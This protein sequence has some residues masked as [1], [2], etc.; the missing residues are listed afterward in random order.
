[1]TLGRL[2]VQAFQF[3]KNN[4]LP[5]IRTAITTAWNWVR[6]RGVALARQALIAM[7]RLAVQAFQFGKNNLLPKIRTAITTAWNWVRTRGATQARTALRTMAQRGAQA[8][9]V[10]QTRGVPII[11]TALSRIGAAI[12]QLSPRLY[13][14][15]RGIANGL[16]RMWKVTGR[17]WVQNLMAGLRLMVGQIRGV[18]SAVT[19][20]I[21]PMLARWTTF[22]RQHGGDVALIVGTLVTVVSEAIR[23]L[24]TLIRGIVAAGTNFIAGLWRAFGDEIVATVRLF[25]DTTASIIGAFIDTLATLIRAGMDAMEGDWSSAWNRIAG[26]VNRI[27]SG[28]ASY[29]GRWTRGLRTT[30][31]NAMNNIRRGI[32]RAWSNIKT[33]IGNALNTIKTTIRNELN[34]AKQRAITIMNNLISGVLNAFN[35]LKQALKNK[36]S[37]ALDGAVGAFQDAYNTVT[38]NS[39]V[40]DMVADVEYVMGGM[41]VATPTKRE[42]DSMVGIAD[43]KARAMESALNRDYGLTATG[44]V[45]GVGQQPAPAGAGDTSTTE[46]NQSPDKLVLQLDGDAVTDLLRGEAVEVVAENDDRKSRA[47]KRGDLS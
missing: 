23:G 28:I 19:A 8:L 26:L 40:P 2:A 31:S 34:R 46:S 38:G 18:L 25:V 24:F 14:I 16:A 15:V 44:G 39:I 45:G 42:L 32:E 41:D 6:T 36:V 9:R 21:R 11:R 20:V 47:V 22:W 35:G 29:I 4:L 13:N 33:A 1:M 17:K 27:A 12:K 43:Q 3:G 10:L 37:N 30:I 5:A 7:G